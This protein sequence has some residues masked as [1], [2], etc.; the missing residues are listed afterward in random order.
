[1]TE[2]VEKLKFVLSQLSIK[3]K[4]RAEL[5]YFLIHSL[6]DDFDDDVESP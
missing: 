1:M 3:L 2:L 5:V 6:D 4:E